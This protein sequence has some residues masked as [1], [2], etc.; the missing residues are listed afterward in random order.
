MKDNV[1]CQELLRHLVVHH[2]YLFHS[3]PKTKQAICDEIGIE[4]KRVIRGELSRSEDNV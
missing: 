1:F 4:F 3:D 2:F